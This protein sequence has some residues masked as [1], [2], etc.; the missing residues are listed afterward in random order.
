MRE[1]SFSFSHDD[2]LKKLG[3]PKE[4]VIIQIY[5]QEWM[6]EPRKFCI[7]VSCP[8][9]ILAEFFKNLEKKKEETS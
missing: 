2:F 5:S 8:E 7:K 3:L 6:G 4:C 9:D 1:I